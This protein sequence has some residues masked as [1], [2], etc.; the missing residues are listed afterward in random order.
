MVARSPIGL[1]AGSGR[2]PEVL[3]ESVRAQGR[4]LVVFRLPGAEP[5]AA[6]AANH[7]YDVGYGEMRPILAALQEHGVRELVFAGGVPHVKLVD[8]GD[9]ALRAFLDMHRD[10]TGQSLFLQGVALLEG[11]GVQV[12]S[13]L[14]L[15]PDLA[16]PEGVLTARGPTE[17]QWKDVARGLAIAGALAGE[18]VGQAVALFNGVVVAVEAADGTDA[19]IARAGTLAR[20][21]VI[22]KAARPRQDPRFDLPAAGVETL[23]VMRDAGA[24][25]LAMEAGRTLLVDR[26]AA[27]ASA[28][29]AGIVIVGVDPSMS[30][31]RGP[32]SDP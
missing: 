18:E 17:G 4:P 15:L 27:V 7:R 11:M 13:P 28:D 16:M 20:G 24:A 6:R 19:T 2:L 1:I 32:M 12:R 9:S 14:D 3:A 8:A 5:G 30:A 29:Q 26:E 25:V 22:I 10:R 31:L 23:Q 21:V